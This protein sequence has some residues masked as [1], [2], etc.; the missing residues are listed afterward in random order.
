MSNIPYVPNGA[1]TQSLDL[2]LPSDYKKRKEPL[3]WVLFIHGGGWFTGDKDQDHYMLH[4]TR[5][6]I[7]NNGYAVASVN[8]RLSGESPFPSQIR[9]CKTALRFL[10]AHAKEYGLDTRR[11][12]VWGGSA[13]GNLAS[14]LGTSTNVPEFETG[15]WSEQ[16]S[17]VAAVC[18][19]CGKTDLLMIADDPQRE[20]TPLYSQINQYLGGEIGSRRE[21]AQKASPVFWVSDQTP[22]F[23]I[24]HGT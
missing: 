16:T 9:D 13:G 19:F 2:Y 6:V 15:Y 22:P 12:G 18:D 24:V 10:K 11:I 1:A 23:L 17:Q 3:P 21:A 5:W 14:L 4:G 8:Y 20:K 7:L